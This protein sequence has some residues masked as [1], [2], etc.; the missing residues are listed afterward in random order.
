MSMIVR[1]IGHMLLLFYVHDSESIRPV[2][3]S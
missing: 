3:L 2:T 1:V